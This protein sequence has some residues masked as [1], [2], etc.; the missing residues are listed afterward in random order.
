M[1]Q[2]AKFGDNPV[3]GEL[4]FKKY[5]AQRKFDSQVVWDEI[6][7]KTL[8]TNR[9]TI[10]T[11]DLSDAVLTLKDG[12]KIELQENSM[13]YLD[14]S[15]K[16]ININF[17]Y[18]TISANRGEGLK[19][20]GSVMNI[21]SGEMAV[22]VSSA[23][24]DLKLTKTSDEAVKVQV[25]KGEAKVLQE[26]GGEKIIKQNE[27]AEVK[28]VSS[29]SNAAVK[30]DTNPFRATREAP[31]EDDF[32]PDVT[33]VYPLNDTQIDR[34]ELDSIRF[35]WEKNQ[36]AD[37]YIFQIY[38]STSAGDKLILTEE[39]T[40]NGFS[41]NN[42]D[43]ISQGEF[44]WSVSAGRRSRDGKT[45]TSVAVKNTF[46]VFL[47]GRGAPKILTPKKIYVD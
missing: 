41:L 34:N 9:D 36:K 27:T 35:R 1:T 12:T 33:A 38:E 10:R 3:I 4:T 24:G 11:G 5:K 19:S 16:D 25:E 14:F 18:G 29:E 22:Q 40:G 45:L 15:D 42:L 26:G 39:T 46:R 47:P 44:V 13:V 43:S 8:I 7:A 28:T 21:K 20:D 32:I 37:Y 6:N 17:A 2:I 31:D 30:L 23:G